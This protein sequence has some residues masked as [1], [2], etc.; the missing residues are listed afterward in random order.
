MN[1][2]LAP[3][4]FHLPIAFSLFALLCGCSTDPATQCLVR[5]DA[6]PTVRAAARSLRV[7][8]YGGERREQ[9]AIAAEHILPSPDGWDSLF[10]LAPL[11][12]DANRVFQVT[13][14]ALDD[15]NGT[16]ELV[17]RTGILSGYIAG[18][19]RAYELIL[20]DAC[21]GVD[22][23]EPNQVCRADGECVDP[24]VRPVDLPVGNPTGRLVDGGFLIDAGD[25]APIQ[26]S[27][28]DA[29]AV[30]GGRPFD[31][32]TVR[33][34]SVGDGNIF[35]GNP[36]GNDVIDAGPDG[37]GSDAGPDGN[38][39]FDAGMDAGPD[40]GPFD[41]GFDAGMDAGTDAGPFDAGFDG[42]VSVDSGMDS[43]TMDSST[44]PHGMP[45]AGTGPCADGM[46]DCSSGSPVCMDV[47]KPAGTFC[48][49]ASACFNPGM[50]TGTSAMCPP[51]SSICGP[52]QVCC[53]GDARC[54][55]PGC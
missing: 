18:E 38:V 52:G 22:C 53:M 30:D 51:G 25:D 9:L 21:A 43:A 45:C 36:D 44:C 54:G 49:I 6:E 26:D 1:R 37:G 15:A 11:N 12:G 8:I 7:T 27:G 16:G 46:I 31:G 20:Y 5:V 28:F 33:D 24:F 48:G 47:F 14:E 13:L 10:V 23:T 19:T 41:A 2:A 4:A 50:C 3:H 32:G 55:P 35:D 39:T 42:S 17:A 40:S 29:R 34:S